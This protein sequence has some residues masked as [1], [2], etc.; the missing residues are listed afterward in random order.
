MNYSVLYGESLGFLFTSFI[1]AS[2]VAHRMQH[3]VFAFQL[4]ITITETLVVPLFMVCIAVESER[5]YAEQSSIAV[6]TETESERSFL[7]AQLKQQLKNKRMLF[8][9][10]EIDLS[11]TIGQGLYFF[12]PWMQHSDR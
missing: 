11:V 4:H 5:V 12:I 10:N 6:E 7:S 3:V 1:T 9:V 8:S 2:M